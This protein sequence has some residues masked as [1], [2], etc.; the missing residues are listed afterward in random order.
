MRF[1]TLW[2]A[3]GG[4]PSST[5]RWQRPSGTSGVGEASADVD[6]SGQRRRYVR[7]TELIALLKVGE[8]VGAYPLQQNVRRYPPW[9]QSV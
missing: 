3:S 5:I 2:S 1:G 4:G 6:A 7:Y 8:R 9:N